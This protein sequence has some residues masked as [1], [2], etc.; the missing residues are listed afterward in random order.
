MV[1]FT[2]EARQMET[3][4]TSATVLVNPAARGIQRA[5]PDRLARYLR[6]Q[7]LRTTLVV[8]DSPDAATAAAGEAAVRG[9][10]LLFVLGG[11]GSLRD[12]ALGVAGSGTAVAAVPVGTVNIWAKEAG[13]PHGV[14][15]AVDAHL[16]GQV[17]RID[18]G[19]A[20]GSC[21][22]LM[23]S[24]GWDAEVARRVNPGWKRKL[25]DVAY[26]LEAARTLPRLRP[27]RTRWRTTTAHEDGVALM[28]ISNTRLYGGLVKFAP[29]A[30]ADD[31]LLDVVALCPT[32]AF[33]TARLSAR[34]ALAR[35]GDDVRTIVERAEEVHVETPA[36]PVQL[37]GDYFGE[38]P[39]TFRVDRGALLVSVPAGPL[40]AII[41]GDEWRTTGFET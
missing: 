41:A 26:M 39:M 9:D 30:L 3:P 29:G 6:K 16:G 18:L 31:G 19:R 13:I 27:V 36:L 34:L 35:V 40:P 14:R 21:F 23:A 11:D 33:E 32:N 25:G 1:R 4:Y 2:R 7:G 5:D 10:E 15:A 12:A 24:V 28:V 22:L 37:D 38:T 17:Q 20:N 8:P